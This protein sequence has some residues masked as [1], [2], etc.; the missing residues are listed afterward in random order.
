MR[1][2]SVVIAAP[3]SAV[4]ARRAIQAR[5][6][7]GLSLIVLISCLRLMVVV[8]VDGVRAATPRTYSRSGTTSMST[9]GV[10]RLRR[11]CFFRV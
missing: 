5:R 8:N 10:G 6:V 2:S 7:S 1:G 4:A 11:T 3:L 9:T